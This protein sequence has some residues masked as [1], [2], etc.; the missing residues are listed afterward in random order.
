MEA[1]S[2][3][4]EMF[5]TRFWEP[6]KGIYD[7]IMNKIPGMMSA[8][9]LDVEERSLDRM[10]RDL[11]FGDGTQ[12]VREKAM[13]LATERYEKDIREGVFLNFVKGDMMCKSQYKTN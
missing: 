11:G 7:N 4:A 13:E 2:K 6:M 8:F 9:G 1:S 5:Y 12:L 3:A 10:L